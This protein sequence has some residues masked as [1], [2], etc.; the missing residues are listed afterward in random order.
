MKKLCLLLV[1]I[2]AILAAAQGFQKPAISVEQFFETG[3]SLNYE[4]AEYQVGQNV[5]VQLIE[6]STGR[7]LLT[8]ET[9][10]YQYGEHHEFTIYVPHVAT[11]HYQLKWAHGFSR[12]LLFKERE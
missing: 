1:L 8:Q 3:D 2:G 11:G 12:N 6:V 9:P 5:S 4:A 10:V 7:I